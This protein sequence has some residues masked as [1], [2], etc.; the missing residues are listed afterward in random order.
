MK[1]ELIFLGK[2]KDPFITEGI[3]KYTARLGHYTQVSVRTLK[4]KRGSKGQ[5]I[6][7]EGRHLLDA[8]PAGWF[9]VALDSRGKQ[10]TSEGFAELISGWEQRG[11]KGVCYLIGGPLGL[12]S[13]VVERADA[14]LS[15]STMTFTHDMVRMLLLEQ[16]YRAYTIKGGEKYHK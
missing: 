5:D 13:E 6:E 3:D 4:E 7:D 12:S 1:H 2:T 10:Y 9:I 14:C 15:L 16:M 8:V 11:L